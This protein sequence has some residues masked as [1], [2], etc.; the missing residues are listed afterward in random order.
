MLPESGAR[1]EGDKGELA[2]PHDRREWG[3]GGE[4]AQGGQGREESKNTTYYTLHPTPHNASCFNGGTPAPHWLPYTPFITH[5]LLSFAPHSS[6][7]YS[8]PY[9]PT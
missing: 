2:L 6:P 5:H 4:G 1:G 7:L 3:L 8:H 9:I